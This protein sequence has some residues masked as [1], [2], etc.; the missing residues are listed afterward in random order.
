MADG[1][2]Q[3]HK[4]WPLLDASASHKETIAYN[5]KGPTFC[6]FKTAPI[7][8]QFYNV[9]VINAS[10]LNNCFFEVILWGTTALLFTSAQRVLRNV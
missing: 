3:L 5:G 7:L 9:M 2:L 4:T 8:E 6:F 10:F 1:V